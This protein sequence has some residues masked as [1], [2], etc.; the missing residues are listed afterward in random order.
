MV[1]RREVEA[2][3]RETYQRALVALGLNE[4]GSSTSYREG[5]PL[6]GSVC[7]LSYDQALSDALIKAQGERLLFRLPW[8]QVKPNELDHLSNHGY[9]VLGRMIS[10]IRMKL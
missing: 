10:I 3:R 6:S 7:W 4:A 2:R 8:T 5:V 1:R 9:L